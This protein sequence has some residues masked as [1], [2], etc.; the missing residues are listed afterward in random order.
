MEIS[1]TR[2]IRLKQPDKLEFTK[3]VTAGAG[4]TSR[5]MAWK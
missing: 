4:F 5:P 1:A 2:R 3:Q